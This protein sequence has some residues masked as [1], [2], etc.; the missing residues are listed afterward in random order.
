[1]R[2]KKPGLV[3]TL[4]RSKTDQ[5]ECDLE[6]V[7]VVLFSTKR[8][9]IFCVNNNKN[10]LFRFLRLKIIIQFVF[11]TRVRSSGTL[12]RGVSWWEKTLSDRIC[13]Y[14]IESENSYKLLHT[15]QK[16]DKWVWIQHTAPVSIQIFIS[17]FEGWITE[18]S[19]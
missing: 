9:R 18:G 10:K 4:F 1:M 7:R 19:I 12:L 3:Q 6:K 2:E 11:L 8:P 15:C 14:P 5:T 17:K 16:E 13:F